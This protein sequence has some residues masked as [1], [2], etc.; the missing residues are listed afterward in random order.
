IA[1]MLL[2]ETVVKLARN[3]QVKEAIALVNEMAV[4]DYHRQ[5]LTGQIVWALVDAGKIKD[6]LALV[7]QLPASQNKV[8]LYIRI[9]EAFRGQGQKERAVEMLKE[10]LAVLSSLTGDWRKFELMQIACSFARLGE[11][12]K[13]MEIFNR[14]ELRDLHS[15][16]EFIFALAEGGDFETAIKLAKEMP[17]EM[18]T[19]V[20]LSIALNAE[21]RGKKEL[22]ERIRHEIR[23]LSPNFPAARKP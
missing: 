5:S 8:S 22:A 17:S 20:L 18:Q 19:S 2:R 10:A 9:A 6:A 12:Q 14:P 13:A 16:H 3:G 1:D 4:K 11:T 21:Q 23:S 7:R 15:Y